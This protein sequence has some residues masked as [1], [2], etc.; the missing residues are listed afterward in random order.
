MGEN[1]IGPC[2]PGISGPRGIAGRKEENKLYE[3]KGKI[4]YSTYNP[5]E[6]IQY[7]KDDLT[8]FNGEKK[9]Q[10]IGKGMIN[11]KISSLIFRY[12]E[13]NDFNT[14][15]IGR[16]NDNE[17]LVKKLNIIPIEVV[18]RNYAAGSI[19]K[20]LGI[21]E[22]TKFLQ[23]IVEF[24]YK[25]DELGDPLINGDHV[26]ALNI[27]GPGEQSKIKNLAL[28]ANVL[29][30]IMFSRINIKLVDFKLEFGTK[31]KN[32]I[33]PDVILGDEISPDGC[34]LWDMNTNEKLDKDN[35]RFDLGDIKK[36]YSEIYCRLLDDPKNRDFI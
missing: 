3:G 27:T 9:S 13:C 36:T 32:S 12:L 14:H 5:E 16:I 17:M 2:D 22:G 33:F 23:P 29:L 1:C 10:I 4:I 28:R 26:S 20:R 25:S 18:V 8:A 11:N 7:F 6:V 15:F 21:E 24:Y 19:V 34:R 30:T 35:F 31:K